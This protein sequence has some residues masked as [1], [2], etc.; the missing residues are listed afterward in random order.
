MVERDN[1]TGK[2][3]IPTGFAQGDRR[4]SWWDRHVTDKRKSDPEERFQT[5]LKWM[6]WLGGSV[7]TIFVAGFVLA[8]YVG[9]FAKDEEVQSAITTHEEVHALDHASLENRVV[10][11]ETR[12]LEIYGEQRASGERQRLMDLRIELLLEKSEEEP[13][14]PGERRDYR[15]RQIRLERSIDRQERRVE[16][17]EADPLDGLD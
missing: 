16:A 15:S 14:R 12:T 11:I 6:K 2:R 10:R 17:V 5:K 3:G 4:L 1:G 9:A 7:V 8:Q 13:R